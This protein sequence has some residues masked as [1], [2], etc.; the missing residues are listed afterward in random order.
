MVTRT[1]ATTGLEPIRIRAARPEEAEACQAIEIAGAAMLAPHAPGGATLA[2]PYSV[3]HFSAAAAE[4]RLQVAETGDGA[5][6]AMT[7][8]LFD[9]ADVHIA[10]FDVLPRAQGSGVGARLLDAVAVLGAE[11]GARR[12]TLTTFRDVP[13]NR[14]YYERRG[15]REI[16]LDAGGPALRAEAEIQA[17]LGYGPDV[18]LAMARPIPPAG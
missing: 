8:V 9:G 1:D 12:L 6:I 14:P 5:L 18:R 17:G 15:F 3:A 11:R 16:A 4:G 13:F 2:E 7:I 10:E